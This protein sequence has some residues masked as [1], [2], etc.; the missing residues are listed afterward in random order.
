MEF[1]N[2]WLFKFMTDGSFWPDDSSHTLQRGGLKFLETFRDSLLSP[3]MTALRVAG[4]SLM[5]SAALH[6]SPSTTLLF[7]LPM[8]LL[9]LNTLW[10]AAL[11]KLR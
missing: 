8:A 10:A 4:Q 11:S 6:D 2:V 3:S 7:A 9:K 1:C 5:P